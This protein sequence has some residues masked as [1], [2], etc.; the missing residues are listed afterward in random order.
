MKLRSGHYL[1]PILVPINFLALELTS[2]SL[3]IR[4][5]PFL[6]SF[7]YCI[8]SFMALLKDLSKET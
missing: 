3:K 5:R 6:G 1:P 4:L 7:D 8:V 2:P